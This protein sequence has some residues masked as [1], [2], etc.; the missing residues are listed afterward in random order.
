[1]AKPLKVGHKFFKTQKDAKLFFS[2]MLGK[3]RDEE[4]VDDKDADL[5][6]HLIER[7]PYAHHK[8]GCGIKR[9]YKAKS[10]KPTSCF[11][12]E[13][14][15]GTRTDF[16]LGKCITGRDLSLYQKFAEACR[17]AVAEDLILA[18]RR[19]FE[20]NG[21]ED[22][23]VKCELTGEKVAIH[24]SHL[25]HKKPMTFQMIV[26]TFIEAKNIEISP[27]MLSTP[28]DGQFAMTFEDKSI[29]EEFRDYHHRITLKHASLRIVKAR[30]NLILG[31]SE[32][33]QKSKCPVN[34]EREL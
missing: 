20:K 31:G 12:L 9:F 34:I 17:E 26:S 23:R 22:G 29:E 18:K 1:M 8:I 11:W 5:L 13:R 19:F 30:E 7:H 3:Y 4:T 15:N 6:C 32:R 25:D 24:E 28:C 10:G 21:D 33:I 16:S 2:Q 14:L 27:D